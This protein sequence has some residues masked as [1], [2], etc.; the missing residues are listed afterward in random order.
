M[1]FHRLDL[2]LVIHIQSIVRDSPIYGTQ[3][4]RVREEVG[5]R[6]SILLGTQVSEYSGINERIADL[7]DINARWGKSW[8][9]S[10]R[11]KVSEYS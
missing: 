5:K 1:P 6:W 2:Y 11:Y 9:H 10:F 7:W 8:K 3:A 4:Y